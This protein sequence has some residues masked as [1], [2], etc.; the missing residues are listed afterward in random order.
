MNFS[1]FGLQNCKPNFFTE[2]RKLNCKKPF[3]QNDENS[4]FINLV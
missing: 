3:V 1:D 2:K 4:E